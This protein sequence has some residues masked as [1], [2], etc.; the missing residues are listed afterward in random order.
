MTKATYIPKSQSQIARGLLFWTHEQHY[1]P[2]AREGQSDDAKVIKGHMENSENLIESIDIKLAL[3]VM[4]Y[5]EGM[6]NG[7]CTQG[8]KPCPFFNAC[9]MP[10]YKAFEMQIRNSFNQVAY[11]PLKFGK[12]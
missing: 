11:D 7:A 12:E 1:Q 6:F 3:N 9:A 8:F 2:T 5:R 4:P 10:D